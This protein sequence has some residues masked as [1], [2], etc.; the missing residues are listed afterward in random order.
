MFIVYTLGIQ[1]RLVVSLLQSTTVEKTPA[2]SCQLQL[3]IR[4][5]IIQFVYVFFSVNYFLFCYTINRA[6]RD[7]VCSYGNNSGTPTAV[8]RDLFSCVWMRKT[9]ADWILQQ[10]RILTSKEL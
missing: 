6:F 2:F 10:K 9:I 1:I 7:H 3:K 5:A 4:S 8:D